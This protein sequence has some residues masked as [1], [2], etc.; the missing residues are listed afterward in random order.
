MRRQLANCIA[1]YD[2]PGKVDVV[3]WHRA[4][5]SWFNDIGVEPELIGGIGPEL[6]EAVQPFE[7]NG[8]LPR[9]DQ[10]DQYSSLSLHALWPRGSDMM[11]VHWSECAIL[12]QLDH[13]RD[14]ILAWDT[15]TM[16]FDDSPLAKWAA[17]FADL[18][19]PAY[20]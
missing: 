7:V 8:G 19:V 11:L 18:A 5:L 16:S 3:Q 17:R 2:W 4:A 10:A 9:E 14:F 20:G 15:E 13:R 12:R 1:F 6:S